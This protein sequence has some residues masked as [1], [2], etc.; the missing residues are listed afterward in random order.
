MGVRLKKVTDPLNELVKAQLFESGTESCSGSEHDELFYDGLFV[1]DEKAG[2]NM[3]GGKNFGFLLRGEEEDGESVKKTIE[4]FVLGK[5]CSDDLFQRELI[6][7]V[8]KLESSRETCSSNRWLMKKLRDKG[9]N[10]GLCI[11]RWERL[12]NL[13]AGDYE[14]ID[15]ISSIDNT[16]RYII[17]LDL[18]SNFDIARPTSHFLGIRQLIPPV[19]VGKPQILKSIIK[20]LCEETKRSIRAQ[21][22]HLPPWRRYRYIQAK[23]FGP[24]RRTINHKLEV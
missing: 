5:I 6:L 8:E 7:C 23:W 24:H 2:E 19:F 16:T 21:E 18:V 11:S 9:Y 1:D 4:G 15:V 20:L 14:Y 10:A 12:G 3:R 13:P 17:D 22:M